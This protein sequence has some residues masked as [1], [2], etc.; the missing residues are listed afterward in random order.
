MP[1]STLNRYTCKKCDGAIVT[2]DL[3]EGTTPMF[4]GCRV[5]DGCD[6]MM[7]SSMYCD[8]TGEPDYVWRKPTKVEYM[9]ASVAMCQHFDLGGLDIFPTNAS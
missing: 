4:I 5:T 1:I 8:V 2:R 9:A 7:S 3:D 6:G